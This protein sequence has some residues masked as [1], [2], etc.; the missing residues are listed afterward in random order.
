MQ[1]P[2]AVFMKDNKR[3]RNSSGSA[4][5]TAMGCHANSLYYFI[6]NCYARTENAPNNITNS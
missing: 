6:M 1:K 3:H 5:Q 4:L 2:S